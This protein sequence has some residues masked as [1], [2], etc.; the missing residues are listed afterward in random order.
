M[1]LLFMIN[2]MYGK[3]KCLLCHNDGDNGGN[4]EKR[5]IYLWEI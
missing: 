2:R 3:I 4:T 1:S 5:G